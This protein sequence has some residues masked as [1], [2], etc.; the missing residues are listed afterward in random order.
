M[1][2]IYRL[3]Y[4][5]RT[6]YETV[7]WKKRIMEQ[8]QSI[9]IVGSWL[10]NDTNRSS[11]PEVFCKKGVLTNFAKFSLLFDKIAGLRSATLLKKGV[12]HRCFP[13]NFFIEQL[14]WTWPN[15]Q[16]KNSTMDWLD[17]WTFHWPYQN[18][19][20]YHW[21]IIIIQLHQI[22]RQHKKISKAFHSNEV[23]FHEDYKL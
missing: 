19:S 9:I 4:A 13:L 17:C 16:S 18:L 7:I 8:V 5:W 2:L 6:L 3:N 15:Y 21:L 23:S 1:L 22:R 11:H 14:W 12:S 10:T 20:F